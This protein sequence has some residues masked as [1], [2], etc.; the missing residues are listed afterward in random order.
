MSM[1]FHDVFQ[2]VPV[3][4]W[5]EDYSAVRSLLEAIRA[6][7][8]TDFDAH[9]A[10]H[11]YVLGQA[12]A[13]IVVVEVNATTLKLFKAES[14]DELLANL[15]RVFRDDM[16]RHFAYELKRMWDGLVDIEIEGINYALDGMPVQVLLRRSLLPG[17][18]HDWS[19]V[20]ISITDITERKRAMERLA[21][22]ELHAQGLFEHSPVSLW[23]E[24]YSD[25]RAYL[26]GLRAQGV[27]NIHRHLMEHPEVV[28]EC[29]QR[30]R[31]LDVNRQTLELFGARSKAELID[32]LDHVFRDEARQHFEIELADLWD[33]KITAEYEGINYALHGEPVDILLRRTAL[34][35]SER[36]WNQVLVAISDITARKKAESYMQYLGTHDVLTGLKNRAFYEDAL[37]KLQAEQRLPVSVL[38]LDLN[39]LK[40]INDAQG[41][42]AG[43][44]LL[45]RAA[46]VLLKAAGAHDIVARIGGDEFAMLLPYQDE[47]AAQQA[48]NRILH[49]ADVNNQFYTGARLSY[50]V[51]RATAYA[52]MTLEHAH[53]TA[54]EQMYQAKQ[55]HYAAAEH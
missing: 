4:L 51:G 18:E 40:P 23:L 5:I 15:H 32:N 1:N 47:R 39:G 31:V 16:Q 9:L 53:R 29:M 22:S 21:A 48:H 34:P 45:R 25:L 10:A 8:V 35:G 27:T 14:Q 37:R 49:M 24:D 50:A 36:N 38:V 2:N 20:L 54:D 42:E 43:D 30:I 13:R 55:A 17:H 52:G 3:S 12:M 44:Q 26:I 46:E 28:L 19:R 7:G 33:G 6:Q 41:H 11:P